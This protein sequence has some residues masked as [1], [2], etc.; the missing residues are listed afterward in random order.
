MTM[1]GD[2]LPLFILSHDAGGVAWPNAPVPNVR[3]E[4]TNA[5]VPNVRTWGKIDYHVLQIRVLTLGIRIFSFFPY[6]YRAEFILPDMKESSCVILFLNVFSLPQAGTQFNKGGRQGK[7]RVG[8]GCLWD[9]NPTKPGSGIQRYL[10][11]NS[12]N[13]PKSTGENFYVQLNFI[14]NPRPVSIDY[15][16]IKCQSIL[17]FKVRT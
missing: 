11:M 3:N 14:L 9:N 8:Q 4:A 16:A 7:R 17:R 6:M 10:T 15:G 12:W 13:N 1:T 2:R 5:P